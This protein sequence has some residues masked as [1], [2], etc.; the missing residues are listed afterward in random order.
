MQVLVFQNLYN[1]GSDSKIST[2][3]RLPIPTFRGNVG[4]KEKK[5]LSYHLI[6]TNTTNMSSRKQMNERPDV[7]KNLI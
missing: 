3:D 2:N 7:T 1:T 4:G 5:R 6:I